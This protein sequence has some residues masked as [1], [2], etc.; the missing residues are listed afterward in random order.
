MKFTLRRLTIFAATPFAL[1]SLVLFAGHAS[2]QAG[3]KTRSPGIVTVATPSKRAIVRFSPSANGD[4][5]GKQ[6]VFIENVGQYGDSISNHENMGT[7]MY[8]FE[9]LGAPILFTPRGLIHIQSKVKAL[10]HPEIEALERKGMR[11][12][13]IEKKT[14]TTN[15]VITM[16]WLNAN[17]NPYIIAK[18]PMGA[19]HTYGNLQ[20][21]A[22]A[23][24]TLLYR[25]MY[26]GIDVVYSFTA[27][28]RLGV[29]YSI[30]MTPGAD[31]SKVRIRFGGDTKGI[32]QGGTGN[33][34]I[35][36]D[37][38]SID[39]SA[40]VCHYKDPGS[41][42]TPGST[43]TQN[44]VV[45]FAIQ[46]NILR[47]ILPRDYQASR[48]LVIDPFISG[49]GNLVGTFAGKA[50]DVN[51]DYAG[52][53]YVVGG[54]NQ[55]QYEL[56]KYDPTGALLWTFSG[57]YPTIYYP[58]WVFGQLFGGWTVDKSTGYTYLGQGINDL[59]AQIIRLDPNGQYDNFITNRNLSLLE[60][61]ILF[62]TCNA[63]QPEILSCGGSTSSNDNF[64]I[65][66]PPSAVLTPQSVTAIPDDNIHGGCCQDVSDIAID[67]KTNEMYAYFN[68][69]HNSNG[70]TAAVD[71]VIYKFAYPY[72]AASKIWNVPSGYLVLAE[73]YNRPYLG[74]TYP[75]TTDNS[76]NILAVNSS[77]LFYW[78]GVNLQAY[79]K[80]NGAGVGTPLSFTANQPLM[81]G[82][83]YADECNHVFVGFPNGT[84]KVFLFN[85]A[86]FDDQSAPDIS[87]PGFPGSSV[88]SLAYDNAR[89]LLYA[90]GDGFVAAFDIS[91]YC[92]AQVY[93]VQVNTSCSSNSATAAISPSPP[94]GSTVT[95]T[96]STGIT[97]IGTNTSGQF[98]GLA[99]NLTYTIKA[100]INE[101]CSGLAV[102]GQFS[103]PQVSIT[104]TT[105]PATCGNQTGSINALGSAGT[106]P[107]TYSTD[108]IHF[109]A[110]GTFVGLGG[111]GYTVTAK[112]ANGC[113]GNIQI[114]ISNQD[115]PILNIS[116]TDATCGNGAGTIT[117]A[118]TGGTGAIQYSIDG[119][120]YQSG[121]TFSGLA[122]G[123]YIVSARDAVGCTNSQPV[124]IISAASAP[125]IFGSV[126]DAV[127]G[128]QQ[129][130][131]LAQVNGGTAPYLYSVNALPYQTSPIFSGLASGNYSL[132]VK[133]ANGCTASTAETIQEICI[134]SVNA[135]STNAE[136][137]A[138]DGS[139]TATAVNGTAP[140]TYSIDGTNFFNSGTFTYLPPGLYTVTV[141]DATGAIATTTV[142]VNVGCPSMSLT[143]TSATCGNQNGA[144]TGTVNDGTAPYQFSLNGGAYQGVG[145]FTGL[146]PGIYVMTAQDAKGFTASAK[147]TIY[148]SCPIVSAVENNAS[149]GRDNGQ[150]S[151][152]GSNGSPPYQYSLDG[153]IFQGNGSFS[154]LVPGAYT[155][156]IEDALR[157]IN[158]TSLTISN[159]PGP[160][161][162]ANATSATCLNNDGSI[163]AIGSGGTGSLEYSLD[164]VN[165]QAGNLFSGLSSD[166]YTVYVQDS[167][168][169]ID[170]QRIVV[171]LSNNLTLQLQGQDTVCEGSPVTLLVTTNAASFAW[172][173]PSGLSDATQQSPIA[174]PDTTTTYF[175]TVSTGP[176]LQ[177]G[178]VLV[179][180]RPAPIAVAGDDTTI[181]YGNSAPLYGGGGVK[182]AW[183]PANFLND[184][185]IAS[186][187]AGGMTSSTTYLLTVTDTLGCSSILPAAVKIIVTP[188]AKVFAGDDTAI[189]IGQTL[190]LN[191]VDL[192]N[193]G[194]NTYQWTPGS[195]LN[196][197]GIQDPIATITQNIKYTVLA[198]T[199]DG[200][201]GSDSIS[202]KAYSVSGIFVPSGFTPN[203][204]GHNDI[205]RAILMGIKEF[206][207]F[208]VYNRWGQIVFYTTNPGSG[209]DGTVN[210]KPQGAGTYVW[211][212]AGE[213]YQGNAIARK[214]TT[215]LIR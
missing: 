198:S 81:E 39:H 201:R 133:D 117:A 211:E 191:A 163:T 143:G 35:S 202:I 127:C 113:T 153:I 84:I 32:R 165:Y 47:F 124:Q 140:F 26:P 105:T 94:A 184:T 110:S 114:A 116:K 212:A 170:S 74:G 199:P 43:G 73:D 41:T 209:W 55:A 3:G 107:Y 189:L 98:M 120:N 12:E 162:T 183:S 174:T 13:E 172:S 68:S 194:F 36:S 18:D 54:G 196:N 72:S 23:Y 7:V 28:Q 145:T 93:T 79:N 210:G 171:P 91:A 195:G 2:A 40:P 138:Y 192:N 154:G 57:S 152:T 160:L 16:E 10:T 9:G 146:A 1:F 128:V 44:P 20:K 118:A 69:L 29:E 70:G 139:L 173:P 214:G 42:Q 187:T 123:N 126:T 59:G 97:Q 92:P 71:N 125:S 188:P 64:G 52:N 215:V 11:E 112:D 53:V 48:T 159:V 30:I 156:T 67:P 180:V 8:G 4:L 49:T 185:R 108:G 90:S 61:W 19:Y 80:A 22:R 34:V 177:T 14:V 115:G 207:F 24:K 147:D 213:D 179:M 122:G 135:I 46:N 63:G 60:M 178:S 132:T 206:K 37:I 75:T 83:I 175:L 148:N 104:A 200:C 17:P 197:A 137:G 181:C 204:D 136:C 51:F 62:W 169:C 100:I 141:K 106:A 27:D 88:Y 129:G 166:S 190:Q 21:R 142:L 25:E 101:G 38:N 131:I 96:L 5:F 15:R 161:L 109:Q 78:D 157:A 144:I 134:F 158:T 208:A 31:L 103:M 176:C 89:Q 155:V 99:A 151:A 33:L 56:A 186:P 45:R 164:I 77:Y 65:L 149:C 6:K 76:A 86:T 58:P 150:I 130:A 182:F 111:G 167:M 95:Y 66:V 119:V 87:I 203:G 82:G 168:G 50:K 121:G 85:G 102:Q 205:L 193:S